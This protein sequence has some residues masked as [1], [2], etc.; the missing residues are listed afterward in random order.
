MSRG[1]VNSVTLIGNLGQDPETRYTPN[2]NAVTSVNLATDES[3]KDRQTGQMVPRTEWHR[4]V[5]FGKRAEAAG[6]YLR[7]GSKVYFRGRNQTRK[8]QDQSGQDRFTT[9]V[10]IDMNGEMQFLDRREDGASQSGAQPSQAPSAN[11]HHAPAPNQAGGY[12]GEPIPSACGPV[13]PQDDDY[14]F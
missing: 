1:T 5:I 12:A 13:D 8:W 7:K 2:G 3:Y 9:E 10:V 4:V 6:Q 14:P 11:Q